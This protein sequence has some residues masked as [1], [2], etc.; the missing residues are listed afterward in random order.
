MTCPL[1]G[2]K[3]GQEPVDGISSFLKAE[4]RRCSRCRTVWRPLDTKLVA[5]FKACRS[6]G[7]FSLLAVLAAGRMVD[8][9]AS[10]QSL[11]ERVFT[12]ALCIAAVWVA[13]DLRPLVQELVAALRVLWGEAAKVEILEDPG[14]AAT[15]TAGSPTERGGL[16]T[17]QESVAWWP[18]ISRSAKLHLLASA[19]VAAGVM[20]VHPTQLGLLGARTLSEA[21]SAMAEGDLLGGVVLILGLFLFFRCEWARVWT[22]VLL[23][24]L[25]LGTAAVV[26]WMLVRLRIEEMFSWM[27]VPWACGSASSFLEDSE[28]RALFSGGETGVRDKVPAEAGEALPQAVAQSVD[29]R[30]RVCRSRTDGDEPVRQCR[31]CGT[32]AHD[33]CWS[34]HCP[35]CRG[36]MVDLPSAP[37]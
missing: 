26:L 4:V 17:D 34:G 2:A 28:T 21:K 37:V 33:R 18:C 13:D 11:R 36:E 1:C 16:G 10:G 31:R 9:L 3:R 8:A 6:L 24:L 5:L 14:I 12:F 30:C 7:V 15:L 25:A 23:N 22:D 20:L 35:R 27:L 19:L 29:V 32:R